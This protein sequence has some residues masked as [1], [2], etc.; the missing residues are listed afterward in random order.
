MN[1]VAEASH[2]HLQAVE[3]GQEHHDLYFAVGSPPSV[4]RSLPSPRPTSSLAINRCTQSTIY[5]INGER[6]VGV[7]ASCH[8]EHYFL[9]AVVEKMWLDGKKRVP[10]KREGFRSEFGAG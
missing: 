7:S 2:A 4:P 6:E 9:L 10:G 1:A 5:L 3:A 8:R